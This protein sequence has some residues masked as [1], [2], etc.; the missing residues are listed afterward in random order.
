MKSTVLIT[1]GAGYIGSHVARALSDAGRQ[2]VVYD[3]LSSGHRQAVPV[4]VPLVVAALSDVEALR[5]T[6]ERWHPTAAIH[7]AGAIEPGLSHSDPQRFYRSNVMGTLN[8]LDELTPAAVPLVFSSS[9]SVYGTPASLPVDENAPFAPESVYGHTKAICEGM[10]AAYGDAYGLRSISLRY[11]NAAGAAGHG[12]LG[13]DHLHKVHLVTVACLAALGRAPAVEIFGD[14]Y[15][16]SDGT[17]E[18]DYIH[19]EDLAA[20]HLAALDALSEG[21]ASTAYN[22]GTGRAYS[23]RQVLDTVEGVTGY[24]VPTHVSDRRSGD[25]VAIWADTAKIRSELGWQARQPDLEQIV[26]SAWQW[27]RT[28]PDGFADQVGRDLVL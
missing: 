15:P 21:A 27:H 19:V 17:C 18:R 12:D 8:L 2:V 16:T 22:V 1:G 5:Q 23:V 10:L 13:A 11:F 24:P 25:P 4:D 20:A 7:L 28:H 14:D 3:D 6:V 9:C 26:R